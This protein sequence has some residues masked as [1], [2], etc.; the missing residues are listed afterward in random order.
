MNRRQFLHL[1]AYT[2]L[3]IP[4]T[5]TIFDM[6]ANTWRR[7]H[8]NLVGLAA[9]LDSHHPLETVEGIGRHSYTYLRNE[10]GIWEFTMPG[11]VM[12]HV[13]LSD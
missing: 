3:V 8:F 4:S 6:A 10:V 12:S 1:L 9:F 7:P 13:V 11:V 5:K 2:P